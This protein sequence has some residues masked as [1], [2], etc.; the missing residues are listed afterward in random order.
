MPRNQARVG[1]IEP[2]HLARNDLGGLS[3]AEPAAASSPIRPLAHDFRFLE[4]AD[5]KRQSLHAHQRLIPPGAGEGV[6]GLYV[7]S[8]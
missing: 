5:L 3:I 8:I 7:G 1:Q 6:V 2:Q 4:A